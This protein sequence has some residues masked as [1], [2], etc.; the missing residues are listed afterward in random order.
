MIIGNRTPPLTFIHDFEV[1]AIPPGCL[2][3]VKV[4]KDG[5]YQR[6]IKCEDT[7]TSSSQAMF[8]AE[9]LRNKL[10]AEA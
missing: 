3:I 5:I 8:D 1:S 6:T 9:K 4:Y 7:R 10:E 2:G